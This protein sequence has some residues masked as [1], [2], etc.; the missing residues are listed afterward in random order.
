RSQHDAPDFRGLRLPEACMSITRHYS[1]FYHK[2]ERPAVHQRSFSEPVSD[3]LYSRWVEWVGKERWNL[4][5]WEE[6]DAKMR[7]GELLN[8]TIKKGPQIITRCGIE[9]AVLV[10]IEEWNRLKKGCRV[11]P[12]SLGASSRRS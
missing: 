12:Q 10:M 6:Q 7:F 3:Q 5:L 11:R 2:R 1:I 8:A 9:T 4:D